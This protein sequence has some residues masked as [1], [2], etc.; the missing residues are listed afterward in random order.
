MR[1]CQNRHILFLYPSVTIIC[2]MSVYAAI[3]MICVV[4]C[5]SKPKRGLC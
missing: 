5:L 2:P 4:S 1:V 3:F